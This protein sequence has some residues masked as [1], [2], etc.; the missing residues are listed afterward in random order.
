[1]NLAATVLF[2]CAVFIFA[3]LALSLAA[4]TGRKRKR[5]CAC[6]ESKAV[7]KTFMEREKAKRNA[8]L[9][10]RDT[11]DP[12]NLPILSAEFTEQRKDNR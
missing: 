6:A 1:M 2:S 5:R 4:L 10:R 9:Y 3:A 7:M 8:W 12:K 11:V